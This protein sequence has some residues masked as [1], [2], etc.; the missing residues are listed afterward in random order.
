MLIPTTDKR[1]RLTGLNGRT[2][3][4]AKLRYLTM[5]F[6]NDEDPIIYGLGDWDSYKYT[7]VTEGAI[8]S[9]FLPNALA[10]GGSDFGTIGKIIDK[11]N[12]TMLVHNE[13]RN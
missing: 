13:P 2:L 1:G 12:T 5:K 11:R 8:D 3:T 9:M 10:V 4:G 7:Y 6:I